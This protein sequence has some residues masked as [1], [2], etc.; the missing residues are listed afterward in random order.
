[1]RAKPKSIASLLFFLLMLL[2]LLSPAAT[3]AG[4]TAAPAPP[5]APLSVAAAAPAGAEGNTLWCVAGA[6]QGWNNASDPMNDDGTGGDLIAGDGVYSLEYTV[7]TAD[8][9]EWKVVECGNWGNTHPAQNSWIFTSAANQVVRF[10]LDT[11]DHSGD[12]GAPAAPASFI[13]NANDDLVASFTAVGDWQGWDNGN[14]ATLMT[15][16]GHGIYRLAYAVGTAG[17]HQAK[18]VQTGSWGEQFVADGRA[19]DGTPI[20]FTTSVANELTIFLLDT[21]TGRVTVVP[22]GSGS[23][24]WCVAGGFQGWNNASDP[25]FDDGTNGD[26]IGGDGV[27]S[28]DFTITNAGR[29]EFKVVECGNW[30][31]A[32]PSQNAWVITGAANQVVKF[33]FDTNDHSG[34]AGLPLLPASN[35]VNAW[36]NMPTAWTAVGPWQ[37]YNNG[38]PATALTPVGGN[39][40]LLDYTFAAAGNYEAKL[41]QTSDWG[42]QFGSDGRS[43]DAPTIQFQVAADNDVV[44]FW[45]DGNQGRMAIVA[46]EPSGGAGHD[47]NIWWDDLGHNS[48]DT[49]F[50]TPG[51]AVTTG[52]DV[53]LR[54][55]A[56]SNDLTAAKLRYYNDRTNVNKLVDMALVADDGTYEWWEVTIPGSADTTIFWYRFIAIDGTATAYYED[57]VTR[58]GGWGQTYATSQ[59]RSWQLTVYDPAFQTPDWVKNAVMYQIFPDRFRDGNPAN[60]TPAGSFFYNETPTIV[61]SNDPG[62]NWN[63]P[64]CDPRDAGSDCPGVYSQNFY[65]GDLQGIIDQLDYLQSL[66]VTAI[67]FNPIFESPSN[68]K[69][70]TTDYS[71]IDDNFGVLNDPVASQALFATLSSEANA[72]GISLVLDGVFNHTS[73]DSHYFDRYQRYAPPDGACES[74][75]SIYRDWYYFTPAGVPGTGVCAGDTNY[76]SWFGFDSLPKLDSSNQD[77][78]DLIWAGGAGSIGPFWMQWAD[79]WRLDVAGDVDPGVTN[80]PNNDYWEGFRAAV[81]TANPNAYIVGEEWNV[82]TAWTLGDEWD[83]T[84]NY[85]FSSAILSFWRDTPFIDNDHNGGSSAGILAPLT[86]SELDA[87]LHNLEE[88]YPPEAF[89][90]MMNLLGSHDTNRPLFMLDHNTGQNDDTIYD[91]PNYDW[92]D[93]RTRFMGVVLLQ[94]TL[95]GAPT[96]YYGD[97]VGLV[98]PVTYDGSTWQDDPYNRVPYPWLDET[99]TPFYTHLQ[100]ATQQDALR[101]YYRLLTGARNSHPALRTGSFDTLLTDDDNN[102]YAYGRLMDDYS[103]AAVVLV[104]RANAEAQ[105]V[106]VDVSGYLP[107][108]AQFSDVL[109]SNAPYTVDGSGQLTVNVPAMSGAVLVLAAPMAA[110]PA[111]VTDLAVT[112][113]RNGELDLAWSAPA[114]ADSYDLYRSLVSGGGYQFVANTTGTTYTDSGLQNAVSY[115][116]VAVSR[117]DSNLLASAMSNEAWGVP[118]H[119]LSTAWYNLQWPPEIT[120]TISTIT[121]TANIYGQLYIAGFTGGS[122]PA[123]GISQ[124]IGYGPTG[125]PPTDPTWQWVDGSYDQPVGNNDQYVGNLLPDVVGEYDYVTRWSSNGGISWYYS[126]LSGPGI[127]GNPGRLHVISSG[128]LTAPAAPQNLVLDGTSGSSISFSWDANSEP[129]LAGYE[130]YR[131]MVVEALIFERIATV[132]PAVTSYV[133]ESV[134]GGETYDYYVV[135]FDTSFNRSDPSNTIQAT[136]EPRYVDVTFRVGVPDYTPGTVYVVG[137]IPEFGPWD[138]GR[139]PMTQIDATT[140]EYTLPLLDGLQLQYKYTRGSWDRVESWGSIVGLANRSTTIEYGT[141]GT[142]VIDNTATDWG[143]GDDS[144]KAVRFWRDPIVVDEFPAPDATLVPTDTQ[145]VATWSVTMTAG[146]MFEV[147]GPAGMVSGTFVNDDAT[148]TTTFTPDVPLDGNSDYTVLVSGQ[149]SQGMPG[150]ENGTQQVPAQWTFRTTGPAAIELLKTVSTDGNCGTTSVITT[151]WNTD[152]TYCYTVTNMGG[153]TLTTHTLTDTVLGTILQDFAYSLAPQASVAVTATYDPPNSYGTIENCALWTAMDDTGAPA[154]AEAC[155]TV[156]IVAPTDVSLTGLGDVSR[157][158]SYLWWPLLALLLVVAGLL[159]LRRARRA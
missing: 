108:G 12:A 140:W 155:A 137:D 26:L 131:Q 97:E 22:N 5:P 20:D 17:A 145:I 154:A 40:F 65:G 87:R 134:T 109:A 4:A 44:T 52:T 41:S 16:M 103:D 42:Q 69:Y 38:D 89:Y 18:I 72:R 68:H 107:V 88:R 99:G 28:L 116:Y 82:A 7:A 105:T 138:P 123:S 27:Y 152:V 35:I 53:T 141:D 118:Q 39:Q 56:A 47:N 94:M 62:G 149:V 14:P 104:N 31:N 147:T 136:A 74:E 55:R 23:A 61:R 92:S 60:N 71:I 146:T 63:S 129:D 49:L 98:G 33:T 126:D 8:R 121:P 81:R 11:N 158:G 59:D 67:Y 30:G 83:A 46:P 156:N 54:F 120:H 34:D 84:M 157:P 151:T 130:I 110:P 125:T 64:I 127:N 96:I 66:G 21:N 80:D 128:D 29:E 133:D 85:Q 19:V 51:G 78:R 159:G 142:Q 148:Q 93:A 15:D 73:S 58:N 124:Q 57:D 45:L 95:P 75:S 150:G 76:T 77:V 25:M 43:V 70:D 90:A 37:G 79:G 135:A 6:F 153:V 113:E 13:V 48:R 100:S 143:N 122:G 115:Y 117:S 91:D 86:P 32:Y 1:M 2:V 132:G 36:D 101:D 144:D 102:V 9:H 112:D 139:V 111:P 114:G 119:D 3:P 24:N 50:R 10:T 106:T